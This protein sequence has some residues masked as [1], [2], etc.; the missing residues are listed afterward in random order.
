MTTTGLC[1]QSVDDNNRIMYIVCWWQQVDYVH[2][3]VA[4]QQQDY[5]HSL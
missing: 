2:K 3:Y 1:T 5:V 4:A